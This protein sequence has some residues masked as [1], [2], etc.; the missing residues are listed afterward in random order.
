MGQI[1]FTSNVDHVASL[2]P[3]VVETV[4]QSL[5]S[6]KLWPWQRRGVVFRTPN[7]ARSWVIGYVRTEADELEED[8]VDGDKY[9]TI[10][11]LTYGDAEIRFVFRLR[12]RGLEGW[13]EYGIRVSRVGE[14]FACWE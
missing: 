14:D 1:V 9:Y 8:F 3:E 2:T 4:L 10:H 13:T 6:R 7:H 12:T 5:R 11:I